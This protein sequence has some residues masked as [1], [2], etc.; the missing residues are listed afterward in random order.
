MNQPDATTLVNRDIS[1]KEVAEAVGEA[2]QT[3]AVGIDKIPSETLKN[4]TVIC[5]LHDLFVRC[6]NDGVTP[7]DW[8][9]P[10]SAGF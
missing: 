7:K 5:A 6:F 2:R 1:L 9:I 8:S 10:K 3:N 4:P